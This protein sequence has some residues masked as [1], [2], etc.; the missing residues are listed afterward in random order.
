MSNG[1]DLNVVETVVLWCLNCVQ[2]VA[3]IRTLVHEFQ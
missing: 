1:F 3:F 2:V